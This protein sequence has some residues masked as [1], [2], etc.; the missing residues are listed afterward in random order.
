MEQPNRFNANAREP[1]EMA[2]AEKCPPG[3]RQDPAMRSFR[4]RERAL[5]GLRAERETFEEWLDGN[6][7]KFMNEEIPYNP[8]GMDAYIAAGAQKN[9]ELLRR[10]KAKKRRKSAEKRTDPSKNYDSN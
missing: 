2:L 4:G 7:R 6:G 3:G 10:A 1:H 5:P 8:P 9:S